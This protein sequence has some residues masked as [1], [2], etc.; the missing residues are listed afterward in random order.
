M[1]LGKPTEMTLRD[2]LI[3]EL[4]SRGVVVIPEMSFK[5]LDGRRLAPDLVLHDGAQYVVETKL[6][7]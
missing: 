6:K 7:P 4:K 3:E 1:S 5:T 2:L